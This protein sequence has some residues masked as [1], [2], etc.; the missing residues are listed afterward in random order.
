M[1][2][3]LMLLIDRGHSPV[4]RQNVEGVELH[5]VIVLA[6]MQRV[7]IGDAVEQLLRAAEAVLIATAEASD[8]TL[9]YLKTASD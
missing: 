4:E 5:L 7:E 9:I 3:R 2:G 6:G 1:A 8:R